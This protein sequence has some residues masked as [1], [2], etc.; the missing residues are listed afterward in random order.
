MKRE[1]G[2]PRDPGKGDPIQKSTENSQDSTE[3]QPGQQME[4]PLRRQTDEAS[5]WEWTGQMSWEAWPYE[6]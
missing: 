6:K 1:D 2:M 5:C 4:T 3:K